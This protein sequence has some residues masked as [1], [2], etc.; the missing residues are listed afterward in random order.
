MGLRGNGRAKLSRAGVR[1]F[2]DAELDELS[3]RIHRSTRLTPAD[4]VVWDLLACFGL[5]PAEI[6]GMELVQVDWTPQAGVV[7]VKYSGRGVCGP[8]ACSRGW[9]LPPAQARFLLSNGGGSETRRR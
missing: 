8:M 9:W 5:R 4:L 1:A 3:T 6:K 2:N 7:R